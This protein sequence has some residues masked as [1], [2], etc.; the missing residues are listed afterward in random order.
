MVCCCAALV[1][2]GVVGVHA[3]AGL[4]P[5]EAF[6][7]EA[8][9]VQESGDSAAETAAETAL[10]DAS[11]PP[12]EDAGAEDADEHAA[13]EPGRDSADSPETVRGPAYEEGS[14]LAV[15]ESDTA[16]EEACATLN[17]VPKLAGLSIE[18]AEDGFV[19]FAL[20]E[21]VGV[22][23]AV[24]LMASEP[25][26]A[27]AQPNY[28]YYLQ[29][30]GPST[31]GLAVGNTTDEVEGLAEPGGSNGISA[32]SANA[33]DPEL[34]EQWALSSMNVPAAWNTATA[35]GGKNKYV[36]VAV[37]DSGFLVTHEDLKNVVVA[38]YNAVKKSTTASVF[39]SASRASHGTHVAATVAAQANNG[40]G[41]AG[42]AYNTSNF[43][44]CKLL[45]VSVMDSDG[46]IYT[47]TLLSAY[48]WVVKNASAYNVRVV[49][50][51][52]GSDRGDETTADDRL[53]GYAI[54]AAWRDGIVTVAA[55]CNINDGFYNT[56]F[57]AVPSDLANVVSVINLRR[58][59]TADGVVRDSASNFNV[60]GS[61]TKDISA[62]GT[63]ILSAGSSSESAYRTTS[64][65]SMAAPQIAGVLAL[66]FKAAPKLT[67]AEAV[68]KLFSSA[69]D[70]TSTYGASRGWDDVTGY[71]E[72]NA[73]GAVSTA[74]PYLSGSTSVSVGNSLQMDVK[75]NGVKQSRSSWVWRTSSSS[76]ATVSATGL[77]KGVSPGQVTIT[78][79]NGTR[80]AVQTVNVNSRRMHVSALGVSVANATYSGKALKPAPA[81][82]DGSTKLKK[83][84]HYK[85]SYSNNKNPGTATV[86]ITGKYPYFGTT[87]KTFT[88]KPKGTTITK[89][90]AVKR[91]LKA[92]W[93]KRTK[94]VTGFQVQI[95]TNKKFTANVTS[96]T[97]ASRYATGGKVG[98]LK[99]KKRY[100]VRVRTYKSVNGKRIYSKW[101]GV[102]S[103]ITK[104]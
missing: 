16:P 88:I 29:D 95:A 72:A 60:A 50:I 43:S 89:L 97:K 65:T 67:A 100:Y 87:T 66:E 25:H 47:S 81:V 51:S 24:E 102:R 20:P 62:P 27:T 26:V 99:A 37:I 14:V 76:I 5:E 17:R 63:S 15:L 59:S 22:S 85:V 83:G 19:K 57:Y 73:A 103:V 56:P 79:T 8:G 44:T 55:A 74:T 4:S 93:K 10:P 1:V 41:I 28:R 84:T 42:V 32:Q 33:N 69:K 38:T 70:L 54:D 3:T 78:A 34:S 71:G 94:Q 48:K 13:P 91:G 64:G 36:T 101:S 12:S 23:E 2:F 92:T 98:N 39:G 11:R 49:S 35:L 86:K 104:A 45:P 82:Y 80:S 61:R 90:R 40:K 21:G 68:S 7:Q 18:S 9:L 77:V 58:S 6:S 75:V 30:D 31:Q 52:L 96:F 53:L 46:S